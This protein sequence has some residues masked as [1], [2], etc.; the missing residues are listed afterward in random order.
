MLQWPVDVLQPGRLIVVLSPPTRQPQ[1]PVTECEEV[2]FDTDGG[3]A[4]VDRWRRQQRQRHFSHSLKWLGTSVLLYEGRRSRCEVK[5]F[6]QVAA[7]SL[8][9]AANFA[10]IVQDVF[11]LPAGD[12]PHPL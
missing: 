9:E 2:W 6:R 12:E 8:L 4:E 7:P 10:L 1:L 11:Q 3:V 5:I